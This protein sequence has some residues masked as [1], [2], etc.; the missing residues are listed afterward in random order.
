MKMA[1]RDQVIKVSAAGDAAWFSQ[2]VDLSIETKGQTVKLDGARLTGILE[3]RGGKWLV[4]QM[5]FSVGV[6]GQ[7]AK[8]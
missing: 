4:V 3:K 7:A 8:Y 5:H 2:V 6:A 1:I